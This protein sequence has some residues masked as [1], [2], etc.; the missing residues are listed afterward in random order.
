MTTTAALRLHEISF[1]G[2]GSS[3]RIVADLEAPLVGAVHRLEDIEARWSRFR[4]TSEISQL[5]AAGGAAVAVSEVTAQLIRRAIEASER[6][7]GVFNP[8]LLNELNALGYDRTHEDL[9]K[10]VSPPQRSEANAASPDVALAS[11]VVFDGASVRLPHGAA[12]DPGGLGKG[13]AADLLVE[14]LLDA[15]ARW[16]IVSLGGD[17]RFG[18][19][20]LHERGQLVRIDDARNPGAPW[21]TTHI[22]GGALATSS[23]MGRRWNRNGCTHHHLLDPATGAPSQSPRL[24]ATVFAADAWWADVVAKTLVIDPTVGRDQLEAWQARALVFT[25]D[26]IVDL[27]LAH[28]VDQSTADAGGAEVAPTAGGH[29]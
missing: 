13:L 24:A 11:E 1:R 27:G 8:L 9:E 10:P 7:A 12:F 6:T 20:E 23:T 5:N 18:G 14:D 19:T 4:P 26:D 25:D 15:G 28:R 17:I 22:A 2:L 16:A 3:C 21:A 29:R